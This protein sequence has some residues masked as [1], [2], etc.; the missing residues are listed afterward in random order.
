MD[1][2]AKHLGKL[3]N[4][5]TSL[6]KEYLKEVQ[7]LGDLGKRYELYLSC[8]DLEKCFVEAGSKA[9][10]DDSEIKVLR[11]LFWCL[12]VKEGNVITKT[13]LRLFG[14]GRKSDGP[15]STFILIDML[16]DLFLNK[17]RLI[18]DEHY[19]HYKKLRASSLSN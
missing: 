13:D 7:D 9:T 1:V 6:K 15:Q 10:L 2:A 14:L 8:F 12:S 3:K 17:K 5:A 16:T 18:K 11:S 19:L 4:M